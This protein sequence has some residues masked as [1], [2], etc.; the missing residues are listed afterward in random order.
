M[1]GILGYFVLQPS[2]AIAQRFQRALKRLAHR[3]PDDHG[4]E[5][6]Q[7]KVGE[8]FL[9]HTRLSIIDL[10]RNGHQPMV[11]P[12]GRYILIFN[13]EIY[14][15]RELRV[16]LVEL[17]FKFESNSDT[18]V[19]LAAWI[20]WREKCLPRLTGMF[21][22]A[23]FDRIEDSL[24]C[25]RD[26]FGIKPFFY[27]ADQG[28]ICFGSEIPALVELGGNAIKP[29]FQK[30]YEYL[31]AGRY[32]DSADTF[33]EG[34]HQL[35]P[36]HLMRVNL[37]SLV[38]LNISEWWRPRIE[39]SCRLS[40]AD[41]AENLRAMF[42]DNIRLHLRSDVRVGAALSGGLDSSAIVCAMRHVEPEMPIHTFS[43]VARGTSVDEEK[44]ADIVNQHVGAVSHKVLVTPEAW[45]SDLDDMIRVQGEPFGSTSIYAQ[46]RV[47]RLA[48]ENGVTV[49]LDG[50]GAD[51]LL[52]GYDGYPV[53]RVRSLIDANRHLDAVRF[54]R[55]WGGQWPGRSTSN[56]LKQLVSPLV[57]RGLR[58]VALKAVGREP[59]PGW[60]DGAFIKGAAIRP[61]LYKTDSSGDVPKGRHLMHILRES[62]TGKGLNALL[63]HGDRNSMR[64][65]VESRVPFLTANMAEFLLSLP[66]NYLI[67]DGGETKHIFRAA[68]RGIVPDSILDRRDKIGFQSPER[69]WLTAARPS[70]KKILDE[71]EE[72]PILN[73]PVCRDVVGRM[74][75][76]QMAFSSLAWRIINY[77]RWYQLATSGF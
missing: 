10:S 76:G 64:W 28:Q 1:C 17:G 35:L 66:E 41:A 47:Y 2:S 68:M 33:F 59:V 9:G 18:E 20:A 32:D 53:Q 69:D 16:E 70:I 60:L 11:S 63:R 39:E 34:V 49:T 27:Y 40:F 15:Y 52:A 5:R 31:V 30:S 74:L 50:Q 62:L 22:F 57:P 42:L 55:A 61:F 67:S 14:N 58:G 36:G 75:N 46:Y 24:Y 43:F 72:V 37:G 23:I 29:N 25:A 21:A 3:G 71:A 48:K 38:S 51:E 12:C 7:A 54:L 65:S 77:T 19:L 45:V 13:G 26:P 8:G 4:F 56:T 6:V 73:A 44:W